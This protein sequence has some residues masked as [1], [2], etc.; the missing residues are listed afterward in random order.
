[1]QSGQIMP[2]L[3][4]DLRENKRIANNNIPVCCLTVGG[5]YRHQIDDARLIHCINLMLSTATPFN[6]PK[7]HLSAY[8][9][10]T[11]V[12]SGSAVNEQ[13]ANSRWT[14]KQI[15]SVCSIYE[16]STIYLRYLRYICIADKQSQW[17]HTHTRIA[18]EAQEMK[19]NNDATGAAA[20]SLGSNHCHHGHLSWCSW[21]W[22]MT[23]INH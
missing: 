5:G 22:V 9:N 1:M 18:R 14:G 23:T 8:G 2:I 10:A 4:R 16:L 20:A 12:S 6:R 11:M 19:N 21:W 3:Q 15:L 13:P 7:Y 17:Q